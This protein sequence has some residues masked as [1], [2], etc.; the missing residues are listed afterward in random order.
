MKNAQYFFVLVSI[1]FAINAMEQDNINMKYKEENE[2][3]KKYAEEKHIALIDAAVILTTEKSI[4]T[5]IEREVFNEDIGADQKINETL[6]IELGRPK[7]SPCLSIPE[8]ASSRQWRLFHAI[9]QMRKQN[10]E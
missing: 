3:V 5:W 1:A 6:L 9:N 2:K 8:H 10:S 4:E 7:K